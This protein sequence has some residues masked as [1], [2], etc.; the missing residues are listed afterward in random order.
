M[1]ALPGGADCDVEGEDGDSHL[2]DE[3]ELAMEVC[4]HFSDASDLPEW[5]DRLD[6]ELRAAV[7]DED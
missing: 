7:D 6:D 3:E 2:L 1:G 5:L 4:E